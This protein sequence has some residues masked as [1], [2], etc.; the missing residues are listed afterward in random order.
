MNLLSGTRTS[1]RLDWEAEFFP[2][3]VAQGYKGKHGLTFS[4]RAFLLCTVAVITG[5]LG[6][7]RGSYQTDND[8]YLVD[9]W[10]LSRADLEARGTSIPLLSLLS[11]DAR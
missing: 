4:R 1:F 9:G 7:N 2:R 10:V 8:I 5:R 11:K 6:G 3:I